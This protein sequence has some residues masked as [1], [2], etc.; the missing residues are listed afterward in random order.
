VPNERIVL[1]YDMHLDKTRISVSL[2]T[3]EFQAAGKETRLVLT[4]Q[5]AFLDGFD[6]V[7]SREKGTQDLLDNLGAELEPK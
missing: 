5:D 7:A 6:N 3:L 2:L 1:S 4:E